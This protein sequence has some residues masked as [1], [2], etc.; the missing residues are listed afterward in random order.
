MQFSG[1]WSKVHEQQY[2]LPSGVLF[3]LLPPT[4]IQ[5]ELL[6][7]EGYTNFQKNSLGEKFFLVHARG[8]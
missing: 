2:Y 8:P 7:I 1:L 6:N 4:A 5:K 3:S